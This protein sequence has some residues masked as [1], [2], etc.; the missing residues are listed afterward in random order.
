MISIP[1]DIITFHFPTVLL[2]RDRTCTKFNAL[3]VFL[4]LFQPFETDEKSWLSLTVGVLWEHN[5]IANYVR[6]D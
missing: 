5:K 1:V 3:L 2:V 4:D 6:L